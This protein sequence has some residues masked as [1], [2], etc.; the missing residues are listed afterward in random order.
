MS[1]SDDVRN[2]ISD[3]INCV[4]KPFSILPGNRNDSSDQGINTHTL[5]KS[6][7][8]NS[9]LLTRLKGDLAKLSVTDH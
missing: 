1:L 2:I 5:C 8:S 9:L 3:F 6:L 7:V 4:I